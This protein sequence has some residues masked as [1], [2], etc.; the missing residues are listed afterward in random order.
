MP[1]I[2]FEV[3]RI[4]RDPVP[5]GPWR[6]IM[7]RVGTYHP[8]SAKRKAPGRLPGEPRPFM[9]QPGDLDSAGRPSRDPRY[10]NATIAVERSRCGY[11]T[12]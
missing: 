9:I 11:L 3:N 1:A 2:D 12:V 6:G 10:R 5:S 4:I 8:V 7:A